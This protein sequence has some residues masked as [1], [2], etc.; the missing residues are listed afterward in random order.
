MLPITNVS[1]RVRL[2]QKGKIRLG[3]NKQNSDGTTYFEPTDYFVCPDEVKKIYG[4]EPKQLRIMFP[5]EG[6]KQWASQYLRRYSAAH[7]LICRGDGRVAIA[8]A[9]NKSDHPGT[10]RY[11]PGDLKETEC[12]P[13][14]CP[15]HQAGECHLVMSLQF[16]LPDCP[17]FGVFEIDTSSA[18]SINNVRTMLDLVSKTCHRVSMIPLLL[19]LAKAETKPD[20]GAKEK[21]SLRLTGAFSLTEFRQLAQIPPLK[22]TA[23]PPGSEP[24]DDLFP[25]E[26][27]KT[28]QTQEDAVR[29]ENI[30]DLWT[31]IKSKIWHFEIQ[32]T[33]IADWFDKN[34]RLAAGLFDFEPP[35]PP[36][37]F[38]L[39]MLFD[40]L[41][42]I[43]RYAGH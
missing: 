20:K 8:R 27:L 12:Y 14:T 19:E 13:T 32:D 31:R 6:I 38:T 25:G 18:E 3:I 29:D 4:D 22:V 17:G 35:R 41:R 21:Y 40:F 30:L 33:Q 23:P 9:Y 42:S 28:N 34:Y 11:A 15:Y 43:D 36:T 2:Q 7:G 24:P 10:S 1:E 26:P 5:N 37:K 39:D 16:L